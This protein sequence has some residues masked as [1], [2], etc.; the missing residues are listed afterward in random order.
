MNDNVLTRSFMHK[1]LQSVAG[2]R[3]QLQAGTDLL[4]LHAELVGCV[5]GHT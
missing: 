4:C 2:L 1:Q 5:P 3:G